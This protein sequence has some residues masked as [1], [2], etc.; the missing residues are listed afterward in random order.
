M[1]RR[2]FVPAFRGCDIRVPSIEERILEKKE[3]SLTPPFTEWVVSQTEVL[4]ASN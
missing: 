3:Y 2:Y 1:V 4:N